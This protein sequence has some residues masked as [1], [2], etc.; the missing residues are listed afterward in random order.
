MNLRYVKVQPMKIHLW[1]ILSCTECIYQ[2]KAKPG[3]AR[4]AREKL[5][6]MC[7]ACT[8]DHESSNMRKPEDKD[9]IRQTNF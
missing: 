2:V 9:K 4:R 7:G 6:V 5:M 3:Q 8:E 1:N